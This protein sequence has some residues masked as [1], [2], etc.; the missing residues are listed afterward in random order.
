MSFISTVSLPF[1]FRGAL[2]FTAQP[3]VLLHI[4]SL[5]MGGFLRSWWH[6]VTSEHSG[7]CDC[8]H[9]QKQNSQAQSL[10]QQKQQHLPWAV[11]EAESSETQKPEAISFCQ[12]FS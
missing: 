6:K 12:L 9:A 4:H 8:I 2:L 1:V 7:L 3:F 11:R 10:E 5:V